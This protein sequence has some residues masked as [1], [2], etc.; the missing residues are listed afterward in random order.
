MRLDD[1]RW[2]NRF[3]D[4]R[5]FTGL[6]HPRQFDWGRPNRGSLYGWRCLDWNPD[7]RRL[8]SWR[9]DRQNRP[10]R[11]RGFDRQHGRHPRLDHRRFQCYDERLCP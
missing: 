6:N 1:L 8:E 5:W 11:R 3:L 9:L 2:L 10:F 4:L 7:F